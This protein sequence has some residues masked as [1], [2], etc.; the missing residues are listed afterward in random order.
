MER[1]A[2]MTKKKELWINNWK[3]KNMEK[4]VMRIMNL[5]LKDDMDCE[6]E[7]PEYKADHMEVEIKIVEGATG[8]DMDTEESLEE[9]ETAEV[10]DEDDSCKQ[11]TCLYTEDTD[12]CGQDEL[13]VTGMEVSEHISG[14]IHISNKK[15]GDTHPPPATPRI[16]SRLK[17]LSL[18]VDECLC[19][20]NCGETCMPA[21]FRS[22]NTVRGGG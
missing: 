14:A 6:D 19:S 16:S 13:C 18:E 22:G 10:D 17:N 2:E 11:N 1:L 4:L 5:D 8:D 3:M 21:K 12:I 9:K 15:Y 7:M 20:T